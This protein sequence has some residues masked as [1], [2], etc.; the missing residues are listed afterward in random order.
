MTSPVKR[1]FAAILLL[2]CLIPTSGVT[3]Q[4][5]IADHTVV[6]EFSQIPGTIIEQ[7][8]TDLNF[9]YVHTSHGS[10]I[11]T[12]LDMVE[13]E[14]A[15]YYQPYFR[16]VGDDLGHN[17]DTSWVPGTRSYLDSHPECNVA[18]FS[19][20]GGCSDNTEAG[21][22]IYLNKMND[23]EQ[24]YPAVDFIYM[25]GHL[26]GTGPDGN[27]YQ[28]NNQ[29]RAYCETNAKI[30][31]DF[32]DIESWDPDGNYYPDET[33]LCYWCSD[34]CAV[35]SCP[36]CGGCAHSHCFNCYLKGKA[37]WWLMARIVGWNDDPPEG[38]CGDVNA[39]GAVDIDDIVYMIAYIYQGGPEPTPPESGDVN[40][41]LAQDIDDIVYLIAYVFQGGF[42]PCDTNG[43][44]DPDC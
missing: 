39:S 17:G 3:A 32:A 41:S 36:S 38:A 10:Q 23:L 5:I 11:M 28:R 43:D 16:E 26:D 25:T 31:F 24:D 34:W 20:C 15:L 8:S 33:D 2:L 35:H 1:T 40:C 4:A 9:Y 29:I 13:A 27:L 42:A 18:M 21:I 7:I 12:G 14:N 44:G 37:F 22:S 30:L 19:W 6:P